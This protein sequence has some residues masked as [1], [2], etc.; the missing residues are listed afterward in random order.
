MDYW[1]ESMQDDFY[2][3]SNVGWLE[4]VKPREVIKIRNAKGKLVWPKEDFDYLKGKRRF[5]SELL[6]KNILIDHYFND[7]HIKIESLQIQ[8]SELDIKIQEMIN[9]NSGED[10]LLEDVIE[11]EEDKQKITLKSV[12]ARLKEINQ[13]PNFID[14]NNKLKECAEFLKKHT[15]LKNKLKIAQSDLDTK[16]EDKYPK[17][18]E[19]EIKTLVIENK[20]MNKLS[21]LMQSELNQVSQ[22]LTF[23]IQELAERYETPLPKLVQEVDNLKTKVE[24]HLKKMGITW[25]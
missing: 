3:V 10:G 6:P 16:L 1:A 11:G 2:L 15:D 17:L 7:D 21:V 22:R 14:E 4:S 24:G 8:I 18:K 12:N 20:W 5:K 13:D 23:R 25:I 9:E 19:E